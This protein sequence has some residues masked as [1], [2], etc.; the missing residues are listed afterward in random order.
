MKDVQVDYA[1]METRILG[2]CH[3]P[4][5]VKGM[6]QLGESKMEPMDYNPKNC[7]HLGCQRGLGLHTCPD[8]IEWKHAYVYPHSKRLP[9]V[10]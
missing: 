7:T 9:P 6:Y 2:A 1:A 8:I 5:I 10:F 4:S 3:S